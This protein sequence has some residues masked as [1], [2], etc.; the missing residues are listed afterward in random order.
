MTDDPSAPSGPYDDLAR[1]L[2]RLRAEAGNP[3]YADIVARI[4]AA[5]VARGMAPEAARPGRTTVYDAFRTGRRRID[6]DLL[7]EIVA[8]LGEDDREQQRWAEA[9]REARRRAATPS[10]ALPTPSEPATLVGGTPG[11]ASGSRPL[12]FVVVLMLACVVINLVGRIVVDLLRLPIYLD[13]VGTAIAAVVLG[14]WSGALV[15][16]VTNFAGAG[17]SG[18]ESLPFAA[19]NVVGALIWGYG[20]RSRRWGSTIPRYFALNILVALACTLVAVPII[21]FS[22]DGVTGNGA[23]AVIGTVRAASH[24]LVFAVFSV[25]LLTSIVDKMISGFA[26]LAAAD[27]LA[28]RFGPPPSPLW[29]ATP[30]MTHQSPEAGA[31]PRIGRSPAE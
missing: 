17:V 21:A 26:A 10:A 5:R 13:M 15:G 8:A 19:V 24:S 12:L 20:V 23:D 6:S 9:C 11:T 1:D 2:Q 7:L 18:P 29:R 25:N 14:P 30:A 22:L 27:A 3:S 4:A 28:P 16:V 31:A